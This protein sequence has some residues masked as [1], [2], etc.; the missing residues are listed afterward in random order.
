LLLVVMLLEKEHR[1]MLELF[2]LLN[3]L[4]ISIEKAAAFCFQ[5]EPLLLGLHTSML[6]H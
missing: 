5:A 1:A 4:V 3:G 2:H 6:V